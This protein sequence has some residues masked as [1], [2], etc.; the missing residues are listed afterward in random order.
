MTSVNET[1][2]YS[3]IAKIHGECQIRRVDGAQVMRPR[4]HTLVVLV[5][6][7]LDVVQVGF[8]DGPKARVYVGLAEELG[9]D[10][11]THTMLMHRLQFGFS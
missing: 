11:V 9:R 10:L 4:I 3:R 8:V 5:E 7:R 6:E 2:R 1:V